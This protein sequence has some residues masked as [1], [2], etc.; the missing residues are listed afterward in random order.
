M[1]NCHA[2]L[3]RLRTGY[4]DLY[5]AHRFDEDT[6]LEETIAAFS[7]L[8]HAGDVR[9]VGVSEW[10]S[11]QLREGQRLAL[12]A[13]IRLV[14]NQ[15]QYSAL[16][17]VP[18]DEV[19]PTSAELGISQITYSPLAQGVLTVK[20][21]P[22]LIS[23]GGSRAAQKYTSGSIRRYLSEELRLRVEGLRP[24][25][26]AAGLSLAQLALAWVLYNRHVT[27]AIIGASRPEQICENVKA[28]EARL[29]EDI[30][31]SI[32]D[33]LGDIIE[34]DPAKAG[35]PYDVME[36]WRASETA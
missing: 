25:A 20:Y 24:I 27:S 22:G 13:G 19:M 16:W 11:A 35:R 9:W 31:H 4:I 17:R 18:E 29:G 8:V 36:R 12:Q 5:Q 33:V 26:E 1:T 10:T 23:P 30:M 7:D 3:R 32:D 14:S 15:P 28:A 34:R 21:P 6:P 2:S